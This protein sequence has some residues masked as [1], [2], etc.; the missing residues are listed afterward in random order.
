[1]NVIKNTEGFEADPK[2]PKVNEHLSS[3]A[4]EDNQ[5]RRRSRQIEVRRDC[6]YLDSVKRQVLDFDFEKFCSSSLSNLNVLELGHHVYINLGTEKFYCLPDGYEINDPSL[7][8]IRHV[9]NPRFS[10]DLIEQIDKNKQWSRAIDGSDYLPG[11]VG[12]NNIMDKNDFVNIIV[13]C[14]T[15][16]LVEWYLFMNKTVEVAEFLCLYSSLKAEFI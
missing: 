9:L 13:R 8:D 15:S 12:L 5:T 4:D 16:L 6:P 7:E 2:R 1:M 14:L 3:N 10:E 11:M